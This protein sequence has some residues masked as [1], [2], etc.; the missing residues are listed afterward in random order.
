MISCQE[1]KVNGF[2]TVKVGPL[3]LGIFFY[4]INITIQN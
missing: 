4:N 2:A 1:I 3:E